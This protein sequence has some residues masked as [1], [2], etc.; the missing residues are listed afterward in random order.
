MYRLHIDIALGD[1]KE[2]SV[3]NSNRIMEIIKKALN[4]AYLSENNN[5]PFSE[6][7][8]TLRDDSDRGTRN[9]LLLDDNGKARTTKIKLKF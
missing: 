6:I 5:M 9:Y 3:D 4:D 8:I 7:G 1:N 2:A